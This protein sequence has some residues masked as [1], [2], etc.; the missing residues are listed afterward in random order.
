M[1]Q[2]IKTKYQAICGEFIEVFVEKHGYEFSG[3]VA[4]DIGGIAEFIEQY[5]FN[6]KDIVDDILNEYPEGLIFRWQD[7]CISKSGNSIINLKSYFMGL[8][9]EDL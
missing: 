8:R 2:D 9:Y 1:K 3:W 5:F 6:F 4:N 7:D